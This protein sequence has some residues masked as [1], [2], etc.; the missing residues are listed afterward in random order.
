MD[1]NELSTMSEQSLM[2]RSKL[3]NVRTWSQR[4][5]RVGWM[6]HLFGRILKPSHGQA[7]V[8]RWTFSV[9]ASLVNPSQVQVRERE[10]KI[11][12]IFGHLSK[13]ELSLLDLPL[14]SLKMLKVYYQ[15]NYRAV[16][17]LINKTRPFCCTSSESWKEWVIQQRRDYFQRQKL[18]HPIEE[19]EYSYSVS[20]SKKVSNKC[21]LKNLNS[22]FIHRGGIAKMNG[23]RRGLWL[24]PTT[25][26]AQYT[27]IA[28]ENR[29]KSGKQLC[30]NTQM[31]IYYQKSVKINTSWLEA[32]MGLDVG[33]TDPEA[34][35]LIQTQLTE[36]K[37]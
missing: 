36:Q 7:F 37:V 29:L 26:N 3:F 32:M 21:S 20:I 4:W 15:V 17:G 28:I 34:I 9:E 10:T 30:I 23:N 16:Y 13:M 12:D 35:I 11:Q 27:M 6:R 19:I 22:T 31:S 24:T 18:E 8:E 33:W 5:K 2:W 25:H 1:L 14:F